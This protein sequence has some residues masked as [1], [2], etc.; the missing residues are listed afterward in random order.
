MDSGRLEA[1]SN[2]VFA[3]AITLLA[4]TLVVL[5]PGHGSLARQLAVIW[6]NPHALFK[7]FSKIDRTLLFLNLLLLFF[8]VAIPSPLPLSPPTSGAAAPTPH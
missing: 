2:G 1:F 4:S 6:V 5:G 7:N 3:V 8:V